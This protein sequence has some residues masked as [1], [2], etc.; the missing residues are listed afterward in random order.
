[1]ILQLIQQRLVSTFVLELRLKYY[2]WQANYKFTKFHEFEVIF[3]DQ[4]PYV[5]LL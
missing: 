4:F 1:M 5:I 3:K 2:E